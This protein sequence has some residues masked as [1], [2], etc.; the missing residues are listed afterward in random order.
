M[1]A[2]LPCK[3]PAGTFTSRQ[4]SDVAEPAPATASGT[5]RNEPAGTTSDA[6]HWRVFAPDLEE[7]GCSRG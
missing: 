5:Q 3:R 4:P 1:T 6:G 2:D 7:A